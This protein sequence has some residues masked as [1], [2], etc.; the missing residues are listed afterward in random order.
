[1]NQQGPFYCCRCN[2]RLPVNAID[3]RVV[4]FCRHCRSENVLD[5]APQAKFRQQIEVKA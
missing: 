1:M 5:S 3:G 4:V 2:K